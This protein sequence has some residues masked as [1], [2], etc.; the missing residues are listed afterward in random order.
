[1]SWQERVNWVLGK[2]REGEGWMRRLERERGRKLER[3]DEVEAGI[4]N[5]MMEDETRQKETEVQGGRVCVCEWE[6]AIMNMS[7]HVI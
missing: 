4:S 7:A 1:M 3:E 2:K 5:E 6:C